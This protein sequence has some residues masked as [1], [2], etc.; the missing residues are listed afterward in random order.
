M[1]TNFNRFKEIVTTGSRKPAEYHYC[2]CPVR[3]RVGADNYV[4]CRLVLSAA[5]TEPCSIV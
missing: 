3:G 5:L 2:I 1:Q 4:F